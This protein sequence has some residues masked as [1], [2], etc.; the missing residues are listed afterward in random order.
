MWLL[1]SL[2]AQA[3]EDCYSLGPCTLHVEDSK[4]APLAQA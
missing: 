1:L 2:D 3:R 4:D